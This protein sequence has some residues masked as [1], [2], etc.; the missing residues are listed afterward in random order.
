MHIALSHIA[1]DRMLGRAPLR[2]AI[3]AELQKYRDDFASMQSI[4]RMH[5]VKV[6]H[7]SSRKFA[8]CNLNYRAP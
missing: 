7:E 6:A 2:C 3:A 4:T 1:R 5:E 8:E